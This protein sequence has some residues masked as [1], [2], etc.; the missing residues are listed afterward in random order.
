MTMLDSMKA[1]TVNILSTWGESLVVKRATNSF[2]GTGKAT[3][4]WTEVGTYLGDWQPSDGALM[5][6]EVGLAIKSDAQV[7]FS[8]TVDIEAG[9]RVYRADDSYENVN[10]CKKYEDHITAFLTKTEKE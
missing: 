6:S 10:Y 5:R 1:D 4:T 9:D 2:D 7:I 3:Q 8:V